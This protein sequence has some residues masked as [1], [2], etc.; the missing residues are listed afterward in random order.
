MA[1]A[2]PAEASTLVG[3]AG[4]DAGVTV[5]GAE[6]APTPTE[7]CAFTVNVTGVKLVR[8]VTMRFVALVPVTIGAP[9]DGVM[10]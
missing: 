6:A 10:V 8:P 3:G 4:R 7:L 1:D 5:T 9:T 2:L